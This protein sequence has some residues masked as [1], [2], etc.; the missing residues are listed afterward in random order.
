MRSSRIR[1]S[2]RVTSVN[3]VRSLHVTNCI[4]TFCLF[5]IEHEIFKPG[6][7]IVCVLLVHWHGFYHNWPLFVGIILRIKVN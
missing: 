4:A 6:A 3:F 1:A 2:T 7:L 5:Y